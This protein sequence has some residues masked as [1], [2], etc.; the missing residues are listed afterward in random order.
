MKNKKKVKV[1]T[2][3]LNRCVHNFYS[4]RKEFKCQP[5]HNGCQIIKKK[6]LQIETFFF[7]FSLKIQS[8]L[9]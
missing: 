9:T 6:T 1:F 7:Y 2:V 8:P 5:Y 4:H 3:G